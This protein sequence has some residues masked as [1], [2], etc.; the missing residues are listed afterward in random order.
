MDQFV[1]NAL[2]AR[3]KLRGILINLQKIE[4]NPQLWLVVVTEIHE[5]LPPLPTDWLQ[6]SQDTEVKSENREPC[7]QDEQTS[8]FSG[9]STSFTEDEEA[10]YS[11]LQKLLDPTL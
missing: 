8:A 1:A 3:K 4:E 10:G 2:A 11:D 7:N 6:N 9:V 5:S